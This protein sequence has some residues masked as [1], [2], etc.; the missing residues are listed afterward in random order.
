MGIVDLVAES[1]RLERALSR[2]PLIRAAGKQAL[3]VDWPNGPFADPDGWRA[4]LAEHHG[5]VGLVM[6]RGMLALDCDTYKPGGLDALEALVADTGLDT[7]TVTAITGRGGT[8]LLYHCPPDREVRS[9]PLTPRGYPHIEVKATGGY[10]IVEPSVHPDTARPYRWEI[11]YGPGMVEVV[12][13]PPALLDILEPGSQWRR[14]ASTNAVALDPAN[15][16]VAELLEEH[17]GCHSTTVEPG[18]YLSMMRPGKVKGSAGLTIGYIAPG[19]AKVW[20]DGIPLL[21]QNGVYDASRLRALVGLGP[22]LRDAVPPLYVLPDGFR[23]WT[24]DDEEAAFDPVLGEAAYHGPVGEFLH[25]IAPHTEAAVPA[26]GAIVLT[27]LGT[28]IGRRGAIDVGDHRH[29]A[30]L[31]VAIVGETST[32]AK[33]TAVRAAD[34]LTRAVAPTFERVHEI[35]GFGSGEALFD[36]VADEGDG[37]KRRLVHENEFAALLRVAR[38]ETTI[39]SEI[40][41]QAFDYG[42][43]RNI[44]RGR[45]SLYASNHH[46]SVIGSI[47]PSELLTLAAELDVTNGWLNR[48]LFIDSRLAHLLAFGGQVD[49]NE[50][51][52]LAERIV[53]AL[54]RLDSRPLINGTSTAYRLTRESSVGE[55]WRPW[56][57]R[58]RTGTGI[59]ALASVTRRQHVQAARLALIYAV[60]DQADQLE[61]EHLRAAMAWT[62]F[63]VQTAATLFGPVI[64]PALKLLGAIREAGEEGLSLTEQS[65]VF[66]R[67]LNAQRLEVLRRHLTD[68]GLIFNFS[69]SSGGRDRIASVAVRRMAKKDERRV[70]P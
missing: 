24:P 33:G 29:H 46:I 1:V 41:R 20:T 62:D 56:Y 54:D 49:R 32:G 7:S 18:G 10:V 57:E 23:L 63:G 35:G 42:P 9:V 4:R 8:H 53:L 58:V 26:V 70:G 52:R 48:F 5:N 22:N 38:R 19:V 21:E 12:D 14:N 66:S 51:A 13:A 15:V 11:A 43:L 50:V 45:G 34:H 37:D 67:K 60:L 65:A 68:L 36:A 47:T 30:N 44:T 16:E 69:T 25:L 27:R 3:D 64:G 61:P 39:L 28:L 6:G 31:F 17:F 59:G 40:V 2:P 55:L